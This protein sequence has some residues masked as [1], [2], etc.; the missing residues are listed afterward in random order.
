MNPKFKSAETSDVELLLEMM[1]EFYLLEEIGF[2][3]NIARL[4]LHQLI[5]NEVFGRVWLIEI[6]GET[7]GY[8]ALIFGFSLEYGGRDALID[9]LYVCENARG[10]GFGTQAINFVEDFCRENE[11][12]ALHL[13]VSHHNPK[14]RALY[15][16]LDFIDYQRYFLTKIL[17][18]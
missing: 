16:R 15:E 1:Q 4:A 10:K 7:V 11:V 5:V 17:T 13:E 14:A 6:E 9:E 12:K 18:E 2:D 8:V 3:E